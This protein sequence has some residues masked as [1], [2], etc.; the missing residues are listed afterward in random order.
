MAGHWA[1]SNITTGSKIVE[2]ANAGGASQSRAQTTC[3]LS[4]GH[5][6]RHTF[7]SHLAMKGAP[8]RA[9][10]ELAGHQDLGAA[11]R[12]MYLSPAAMESAI[13]LLDHRA[14]TKGGGDILETG[15]TEIGKSS[16]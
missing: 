15:S 4:G 16:R 7:C 10:R 6:L 2:N 3:S 5:V 13:H 11:Q 9:I 8:A 12:D 14:G 1:T